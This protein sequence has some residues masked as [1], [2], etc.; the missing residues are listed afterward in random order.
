M[1]NM[2]A[3]PEVVRKP[4][5]PGYGAAAPA[6]RQYRVVTRDVPAPRAKK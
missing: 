5:A 4:I 3:T 6:A 2:T 1:T